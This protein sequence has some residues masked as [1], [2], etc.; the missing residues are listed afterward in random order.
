MSRR[1]EGVSITESTAPDERGTPILAARGLSAGYGGV[2]VVRDLDLR[3]CRGEVV[4][5]L[6]RNG[7]G[8]TTTLATLA[9]ALKAIGGDILWSGRPV[10]HP[11]Y[12]RARMG[13]RYVTEERSV[14]M[15]L[16]AKENLRL[17]RGS[18]EVALEIFPEL[19]PLLNVRARPAVRWR[20]ADAD[21]RPRTGCSTEG[22]A[23]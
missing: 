1:G 13:L 23:H 8:K 10:S 16:S 12:R 11:L 6:G 9:G 21:T 4:A 19:K 14:F 18:V 3:V 5:L 2:A 17:G 7:A 22:F 15:S 20:A